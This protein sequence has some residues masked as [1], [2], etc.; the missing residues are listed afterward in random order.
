MT[1]IID[2][3][4]QKFGRLTVVRRC[5]TNAHREAVWECICIC[6]NTHYVPG[7]S[8]RTGKSTSCGCYKSDWTVNK[9]TTHGLSKHPL[10]AIW[11]GMKTRCYDANRLKFKDYGSRGITV[12]D[13][14]RNDF[15]AFYDWSIANG[16]VEGLSIDRIDNDGNYE[17]S[18]CRWAD[19]SVQANN[20]RHCHYITYNGET[21][22]ISQWARKIGLKPSTLNVRIRS[23]WSIEKALTTPLQKN[24]YK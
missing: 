3:T 16:W 4:G 7:S 14:W 9:F 18:N 19:N 10:H 6:G 17:P 15:K 8:L 21:L 5:G 22:T 13:E 20:S 1:Q 2:H 24:Q 12:C 11:D 23:G